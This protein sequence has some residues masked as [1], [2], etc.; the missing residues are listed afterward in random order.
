MV[1][2]ELD[3]SLDDPKYVRT[4]EQREGPRNQNVFPFSLDV[5]AKQVNMMIRYLTAEDYWPEVDQQEHQF[6][7]AETT[8]SVSTC[9]R[10][11]EFR[12]RTAMG[13]SVAPKYLQMEDAGPWWLEWIRS[14]R[15]RI[16]QRIR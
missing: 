12:D 15:R 14:T 5:A 9:Y 4:L 7:L 2:V 10:S 13:D 8:T 11:C 1:A 3:G 6:V 16:G